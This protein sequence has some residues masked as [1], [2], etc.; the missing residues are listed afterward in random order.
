[1]TNPL[2]RP[3]SYCK[4]CGSEIKKLRT[5]WVDKD[6]DSYCSVTRKV[7]EPKG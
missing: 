5:I 2:R 1:M 4:H 6:N 7:H 3:W